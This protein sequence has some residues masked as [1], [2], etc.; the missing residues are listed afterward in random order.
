ML[1]AA[2]YGYVGWQQGT[3]FYGWSA[4]VGYGNPRVA[5]V[6]SEYHWAASD[7]YIHC[8]YSCA[9]F[10]DYYAHGHTPYYAKVCAYFCG[11]DSLILAASCD[12]NSCNSGDG[13]SINISVFDS[14]GV[15]I[16]IGNS[17]YN[18]DR[19]N[20]KSVVERKR[21]VRSMY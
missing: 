10:G 21:S 5:P 17:S 16:H 15:D 8:G 7:P 1:A 9:D 19:G 4:Q 18:V 13:F 14:E 12:Y 2:G 11:G 3:G 6:L 20:P